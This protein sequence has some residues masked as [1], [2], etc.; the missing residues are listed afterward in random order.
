[1]CRDLVDSPVWIDHLRSGDHTLRRL[2]DEQRVLI[3]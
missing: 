3:H 2:L 1:M